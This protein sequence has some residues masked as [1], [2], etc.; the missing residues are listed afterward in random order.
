[1]KTKKPK[2]SKN[3]RIVMRVS[4]KKL[5]KLTAQALA[6]CAAQENQ[7]LVDASV[8]Q[9]E[10]LKRA[11]RRD[12]ERARKAMKSIERMARESAARGERAC[13]VY[14]LNDD[15]L[16]NCAGITEPSIHALSGAASHISLV[17]KKRGFD[18]S[19]QPGATG[20]W[21]IVIG[22]SNGKD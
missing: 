12:R 8:E 22:W 7:E 10:I 4:P 18:V 21:G 13:R 14:D 17:L 2:N 5:S 1:M 6:R 9:D 19:I 20:A 11:E 15:E 3:I 16:E